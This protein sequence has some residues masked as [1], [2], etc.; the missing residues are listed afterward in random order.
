M[1][2][3]EFYLQR[4][5]MVNGESTSRVEIIVDQIIKQNFSWISYKDY[6]DFYSIAAQVL[7]SCVKTF[8]TSKN[9][10]FHNYF[11]SCLKN[12]IKTHITYLNRKKRKSDA[13]LKSIHQKISQDSENTIEETI[14]SIYPNDFEE[15]I[16]IDTVLREI[17][18]ILKPKEIKVIE[19][20]F[21]GFDNRQISN[22]LKI[23]V[24]YIY[25]LHKKLANNSGI[26]RIV[27]LNGYIEG[28]QHYEI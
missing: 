10:S 11:I 20:A 3:L 6:D 23:N 1:N 25:D 12:K 19:L 26:R 21:R 22:I 28:G 27:R 18:E 2:Y 16:S 4:I 17:Y 8:D 7:W 15:N 24:K 13:P 5:P 9:M 14:E